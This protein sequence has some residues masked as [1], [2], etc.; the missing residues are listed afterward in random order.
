MTR[1]S[2]EDPASAGN[3][4]FARYPASVGDPASVLDVASVGDLDSI[5]DLA[6]VGDHASVGYHASV[7]DPTS[8]G[9]STSTKYTD[10][11][12]VISI[13]VYH[14][15]GFCWIPCLYRIHCVMCGHPYRCLSLPRSL[16]GTQPL[17]SNSN[18]NVCIRPF[19]Q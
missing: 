5:G 14:D 2:S 18:S 10:L 6:S 16:Q 4:V 8:A 1:A 13:E 12:V 17:Y 3:L 19:M 7:A 11:C 9:D 15:K